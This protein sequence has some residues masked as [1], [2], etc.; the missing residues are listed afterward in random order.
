MLSSTQADRL[1]TK[2]GV[3]KRVQYFEAENL[4]LEH[5]SSTSLSLTFRVRMGERRQCTLTGI[6]LDAFPVSLHWCLHV[7]TTVQVV[8]PHFTDAYAAESDFREQKVFLGQV[9][10]ILQ[11]NASTSSECRPKCSGSNKNSKSWAVLWDW[12]FNWGEN[13]SAWQHAYPM[14]QS[15]KR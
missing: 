1:G 6:V 11:V 2:P 4:D 8:L 15:S 9:S 14:V 13:A 10:V 7:N 12:S 5:C 3:I